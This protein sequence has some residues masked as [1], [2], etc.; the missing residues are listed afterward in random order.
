MTF[1]L[2]FTFPRNLVLVVPNR[3]QNAVPAIFSFALA[4]RCPNMGKN[5]GL[6]FF[7]RLHIHCSFCEQNFTHGF[8]RNPALCLCNGLHN[9]QLRGIKNRLPNNVAKAKIGSGGHQADSEN[10]VR[11]SPINFLI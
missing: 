2:I 1:P 9:F 3:G 11:L 4:F 10:I 8:Y 5:L 6:N 7:I